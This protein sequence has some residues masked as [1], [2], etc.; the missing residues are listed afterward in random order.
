MPLKSYVETRPDT[1]RYSAPESGYDAPATVDD[2][3]ATALDDG[4]LDER[5]DIVDAHQHRVV[6]VAV[7][8]RCVDK[9]GSDVGDADVDM[10]AVGELVERLQI[11][12]LIA[13]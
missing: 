4:L 10:L 9:S 1:I 13:L 11:G 3:Y 12:P 5:S 2:R 7:E 6:V 8:E